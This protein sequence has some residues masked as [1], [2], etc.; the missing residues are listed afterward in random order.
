MQCDDIG[1]TKNNDDK[2]NGTEKCGQQP[3]DQRID[4]TVVESFAHL[5]SEILQLTETTVV[6]IEHRT[7]ADI[8]EM[9]RFRE[10]QMLKTAK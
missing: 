9:V 3:F 5:D 7:K 10:M 8:G 6:C 1:T 4:T 2:K